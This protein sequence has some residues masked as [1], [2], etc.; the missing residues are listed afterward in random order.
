M[1]D[2]TVQPYAPEPQTAGPAGRPLRLAIAGKGGSGKT[3]LAGTLARL[4]ARRGREVVAIDADTNPNLAT[5]LGLRRGDR[6]QQIAS[7]PRT[8]LTRET[9]PDGTVK[10]T[11]ARAPLEVLEEYGTRARDGVRLLV[12]GA[13]GHGG[14]G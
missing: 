13:V 9:L 14:A 4:L 2:N 3:T 5:T 12:M 11:F 10:T 6:P 7:L 8:L 1:S